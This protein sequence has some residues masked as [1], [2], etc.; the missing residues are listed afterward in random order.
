VQRYTAAHKT[1]VGLILTLHHTNKVL[2]AH[3]RG[4][5]LRQFDLIYPRLGFFC[6]LLNTQSLV[7][8]FVSSGRLDEHQVFDILQEK[9]NSKPCRNQGFVLDSFPKTYTQARMNFSGEF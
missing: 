3:L 4:I 9:L 8:H 7:C 5:L 6:V 1:D 2:V